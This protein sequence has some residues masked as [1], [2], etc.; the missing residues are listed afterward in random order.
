MAVAPLYLADKSALARLHLPPV[1]RRLG[2]LLVD[3]L[4]ATTPIVD[5]KVLYSARSPADYEEILAER[6][7]LPSYPLTPEVTDR[8]IDVQ[9]RLARLGRHRLPL[10]DLLI[11][12]VAELNDLIVMH[13]DADY[14]RIA[15]ITGQRCEW[16]IPRG[17]I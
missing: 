16:V 13:Y 15:E 17:S 12:A 5:L 9:H 10:P 6:R 7:A 11:A 14:D 1:A 2:P 3:G 4:V 8:A